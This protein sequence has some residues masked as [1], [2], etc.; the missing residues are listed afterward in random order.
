M[1]ILVIE[2]D[3]IFAQTLK[4]ALNTQFSVDIAFSG[5]D[6]CLMATSGTHDLCIID[7]YLP[8]MDGREVCRMIK[9]TTPQLPVIFM[10]GETK[11]PYKVSSLDAGADD[12]ITKPFRAPELLARIRAV[13]R[14]NVSPPITGTCYSYKNLTLDVKSRV[15]RIGE[16]I[17]H[18]SNKEFDIILLLVKSSNR[19]VSRARI[20]A[21]TWQK[22]EEIQSNILDVYI[23]RLR[24]KL[25][26]DIKIESVYSSGYVLR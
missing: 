18:L 12:Y 21:S 22:Y 13:M 10:T 20:I 24:K 8:D 11:I 6:G 5:E 2:D 25:P 4:D 14:R 3:I 9:G 26:A 17:L 19:T 23:S 16:T 7:L 1:R 15:C